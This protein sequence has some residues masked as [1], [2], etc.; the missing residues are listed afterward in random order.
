MTQTRSG[1]ESTTVVDHRAIKPVER[2]LQISI[3][4]LGHCDLK[5]IWNL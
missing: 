3:L 1:V 4:G 5:F 2:L